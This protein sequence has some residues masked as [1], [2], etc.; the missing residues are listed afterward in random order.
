MLRETALRAT[1][2]KLIANSEY[3]YEGGVWLLVDID[4]SR[5]STTLLTAGNFTMIKWKKKNNLNPNVI[6]D[7]IENMKKHDNGKVSFS[8]V[9]VYFA[10]SAL[11]TMIDF[12]KELDG[13]ERKKYIWQAICVPEKLTKESVIKKINELFKQQNATRE[14]VFHILSSISL[15][16]LQQSRIIEIENCKK[17][18]IELLDGDFPKEYVT[19]RK[20]AIK[21][22]K[23]SL[24]HSI[25]SVNDA[26]DYSKIIVTV[27]EKSANR[28]VTKALY[29]L[30]LQ[31]A[32]WCLLSNPMYSGEDEWEPINRIRLG[33]IHTVHN[34]DGE[35]ASNT[36][37]WY[38][39]NFVQAQLF[40]P[41]NNGN[42]EKCN[43]YY[44][45]QLNKSRYSEKLKDAL[46]RYVRAFDERDQ[47]NALIKSWGAIEN[48]TV[49][50]SSQ[51][52]PDSLIKRCS[53]LFTEHDYHKQILEHLR[54]YRNGSVHAGDQSSE[55]KINCFQLQYYFH[56]LIK[57]HLD[58]AEEFD[59][60]GKA[61]EF[62]DL[63]P[64]KDSLSKRLKK[65]KSD[66]KLIN[67]ALSFI[68]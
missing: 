14:S 16:K 27:K 34:E 64:D 53:F 51:E 36:P 20:T 68:G 46:L 54:E 23:T 7:N 13:I 4:V 55:A 56:E 49:L 29:Y 1:L 8:G 18:K 57:F 45:T 21:T 26:N 3:E 11:E 66:E 28:A 19:A 58:R 38:E 59:S 25:S 6:L 5:L 12:P 47:N 41:W 15:P 60:I 43:E 10:R 63:P 9:E 24:Q 22:I 2:G 44:L 42:F 40:N 50:F 35:L 65:I 32:I 67:S 31:R 33:Q 62:L 30:D 39:P 37:F 17:D 52:K 61:N 48:L